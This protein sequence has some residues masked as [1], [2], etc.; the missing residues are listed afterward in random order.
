M[1][2]SRIKNWLHPQKFK[3]IEAAQEWARQHYLEH[4]DESS[5]RLLDYLEQSFD[6]A[7][8]LTIHQNDDTI[9]ISHDGTNAY[10]KWDDGQLGIQTD[11]GTNTNTVVK[12]GGKGTGLGVFRVSDEDDAEY[13]NITATAGTGIIKVDGATPSDLFFN[14]TTN[15]VKIAQ[16]GQLTLGG[17]A[18]ITNGLWI[19]AGGIKAPGAKPATAIAHGTLETPAWQFA[20]Q[21]VA[22]NQETVSWSMRIPSRMDRSVAPNTTIGWSADGVSPGVCEWQLEYLWTAP[23]ED[24]GAAAQETLTATGTATATADG[25]VA[26]TITGIDVPSSTDVCIHCRLTRLS[27]GG[28][29]TIADTVE[30]HGICFG[31]TM[32]KLGEAS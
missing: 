29:D 8:P 12:I 19:D 4:Q 21:A 27:A 32:N 10:L 18:R 22:G 1:A 11:E 5:K 25:L 16:T 15:Y 17:T 30:L 7:G 23:G 3:D 2:L 24:T 9:E 6:C 13:V 31:F 14:G 26:T 20:D 28:N